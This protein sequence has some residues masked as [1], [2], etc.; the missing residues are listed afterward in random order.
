MLVSTNNNNNNMCLKNDL[1]NTLYYILRV[2]SNCDRCGLKR[3]TQNM[4]CFAKVLDGCPDMKDKNLCSACK[5]HVLH[6]Y[7]CTQLKKTCLSSRL[8]IYDRQEIQT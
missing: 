1:K 2:M 3:K 8:S 6:V 4:S 5:N 7:A